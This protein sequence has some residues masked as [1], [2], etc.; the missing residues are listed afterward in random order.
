[1]S[2]D[3]ELERMLARK[4]ERMKEA[5][6]TNTKENLGPDKPLALTDRTFKETV[7]NHSFVVVDC[8]A[9]WCTPCR[10]IAPIIDELARDYVGKILFGKLNV[11]ESS[12]VVEQYQVMSIPT[13]LVFK[14]GKFV[15]RI[16][17]AQPRNM[18]ES[19]ITRYL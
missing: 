12:E 19:N 4:L 5:S 10:M 1:M 18:L 2:E 8:W 11:D 13:L 16:V 6:K 7:K 15:D 3:A 9:S 14:N 17:G